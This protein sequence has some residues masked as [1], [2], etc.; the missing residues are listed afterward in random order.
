MKDMM[1]YVNDFVKTVNP[2]ESIASFAREMTQD[3]I[4]EKPKD[5]FFLRDLC[6]PVQSYYNYI[7]ESQP[8]ALEIKTKMAFGNKLHKLANIWFRKIPGY[9][10]DEGVIDGA[11]VDVKGV[12]GKIDAIIGENILEIKTKDELPKNPEEIINNYIQDIEQLVF[13][14]VLYKVPKEINYLIFISQK[15]PFEI[16][17]FKI[18]VKN[19][20][21]IRD[22]IRGRIK[23]LRKAIDEKDPSD[24]HSLRD[25]KILENIEISHDEEFTNKL[26]KFK[27]EAQKFN[28]DGNIFT[29]YDILF[30]RKYGIREDYT[31]DE[32]K[33]QL[34]NYLIG[35]VGRIRE[36][37]LLPSEHEYVKNLLREPNMI[38]GH[39]WV[40][41]L[42][43]VG[44]NK[45]RIIPYI[46][47]VNKT[48]MMARPHGYHLAE[49][50]I[51][52]SVYGK[53]KG[54]IFEISPTL[55]NGIRVFDIEYNNPHL[56]LKKVQE[57]IQNIREG[58]TEDLP[59]NP[60]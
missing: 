19:S 56:I 13:Y 25:G 31:P 8:L 9:L 32:E 54:L 41:I 50:G 52:C 40:K 4:K 39:R 27:E 49:L 38:I 55:K 14:S 47:T 44:P 24:L 51:I 28:K 35:I 53:T 11:F 59:P 43:S 37:R 3:F 36:F 57:I 60:F 15:H 33:I 20:H 23:K 12:R 26:K 1:S 30:P 16:S 58:K 21:K 42:S 6:N 5:Y 10:V 48:G 34:K 46:V 2:N 18:I 7:G 22:V 17:V 45:E 29:T